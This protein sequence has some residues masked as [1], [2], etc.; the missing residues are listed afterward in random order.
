ML[1]NGVLCE[2]VERGDDRKEKE[3]IAQI[4]PKKEEKE[5]RRWEGLTGE[6]VKDKE[7]PILKK[8]VKGE[9]GGGGRGEKVETELEGGSCEKT[10]GKYFTTGNLFLLL[11][12]YLKN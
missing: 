12:R 2:R 10:F 3:V 5:Q 11:E 9:L 4:K 6:E 1:T 8:V 7:R